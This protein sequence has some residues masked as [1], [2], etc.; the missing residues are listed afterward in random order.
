MSDQTPQQRLL[1]RW[2]QGEDEE[3]LVETEWIA[4]Q[5]AQA[6]ERAA[7]TA[8]EAQQREEPP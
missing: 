6:V 2:L 7:R 8:M 3:L 5:I 1:Q 4:G